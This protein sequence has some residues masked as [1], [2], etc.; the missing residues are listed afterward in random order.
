MVDDPRPPAARRPPSAAPKSPVAPSPASAPQAGSQ[1]SWEATV[2]A[3]M[4]RVLRASLGQSGERPEAP[5]ARATS[6]PERRRTP[7][8][9]PTGLRRWLGGPAKPTQRRTRT[10]EI[11]VAI[12]A[13]LFAFT[14]RPSGAAE[15][16]TAPPG[17]TGPALE[18]VTTSLAPDGS[19]Q[20]QNGV[21]VQ[22]LGVTLPGADDAPVVVQTAMRTLADVV[23]GQRVVV[24]YDPLL[25]ARAQEGQPTQIGYV[26]L[27]GP[28]GE[29]R[30]M[31]NALVLRYGFG[32]PVVSVGYRY[33]TRFAEATR[34]AQQQHAGVW[35]GL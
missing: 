23:K 11:G 6:Q 19:L 22:M 16:G 20:L 26:W 18:G 13:L 7:A 15:A 9:A 34:I 31:L 33:R 3:G 35:M 21:R 4:D 27:V 10:L 24:E 12:A 17:A 2:L 5:P 28:Q 1:T 32:R 29:R 8:A 25:P 30:G 14:Q